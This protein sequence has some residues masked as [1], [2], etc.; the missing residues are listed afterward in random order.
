MR[1]SQSAPVSS[2]PYP[3]KLSGK[4]RVVVPISGK[5]FPHIVPQHFS[6]K[7]DAM[8]WL[9]T[10]AGKAAVEEATRSGRRGSAASH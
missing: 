3:A 1:N 9:E 4:W 2:A 7:S 6:S 5:L 10:P 8:E